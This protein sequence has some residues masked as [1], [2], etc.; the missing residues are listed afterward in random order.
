[1][2]YI[3]KTTAEVA[4]E[5]ASKAKIPKAEAPKTKAPAAKVPKT[6]CLGSPPVS[7]P[8]AGL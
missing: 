2:A 6:C 5:Q 3:P 4:K 1:M 8:I 7:F